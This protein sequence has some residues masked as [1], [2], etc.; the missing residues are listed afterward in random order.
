M[1]QKFRIGDLTM[2][3]LSMC[4]HLFY[5]MYRDGNGRFIKFLWLIEIVR[6]EMNEV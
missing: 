4:Q 2:G 6:S 1:G 3:N 5:E